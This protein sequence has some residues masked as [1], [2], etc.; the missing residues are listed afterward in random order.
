MADNIF[1]APNRGVR[2][3]SPNIR[4]RDRCMKAGMLTVSPEQMDFALKSV[5]TVGRVLGRPSAKSYFGN[6]GERR[7]I[8]SAL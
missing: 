6:N 7:R 4:I 8:V 5:D 2:N 1:Y 3:R